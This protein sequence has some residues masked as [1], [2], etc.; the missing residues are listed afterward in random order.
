MKVCISF[1]PARFGLWELQAGLDRPEV[2]RVCRKRGRAP[3][4]SCRRLMWGLIRGD[5]VVKAPL[6]EAPEETARP[7]VRLKPSPAL[8]MTATGADNVLWSV[9]RRVEGRD[10]GIHRRGVAMR[11]RAHGRRG[12]SGSRAGR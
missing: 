6:D 9:V 4:G 2:G 11:L 3:R 1:L 12:H 7:L 8:A 10:D 5:R